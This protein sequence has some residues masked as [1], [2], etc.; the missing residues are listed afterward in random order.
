MIAHTRK[1]HIPNKP[2]EEAG[3]LPCLGLGLLVSGHPSAHYLPNVLAD[4]RIEEVFDLIVG[5]GRQVSSNVG[6]AVSVQLVFFDNNKLLGK[7]PRGVTISWLG[8][9]LH[10]LRMHRSR[11]LRNSYCRGIDKAG[12]QS[13]NGVLER[14]RL[15]GH[16][17]LRIRDVRFR[18]T[19]VHI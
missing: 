18:S 5:P 19:T 6:P 11:G 1:K 9:F 8:S 12:R 2:Y 4:A 7:R 16:L 14:H 10:G 13:R 3:D 15:R 17:V